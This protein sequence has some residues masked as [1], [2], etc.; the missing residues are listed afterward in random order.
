MKVEDH[1]ISLVIS[2]ASIEFIDRANQMFHERPITIA[3]FC[4][5]ADDDAL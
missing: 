1:A 5:L 2:K 3:L 4:K